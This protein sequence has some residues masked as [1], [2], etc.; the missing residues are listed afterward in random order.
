LSLPLL[1]VTSSTPSPAAS[2]SASSVLPSVT[3]SPT[4]SSGGLPDV[5]LAS[6]KGALLDACG[7]TP[8]FLCRTVYDTTHSTYI[9]SGAEVLLGTPLTILLILVIAA[10]LRTLVHRVI[11]R[12]TSR[13]ASHGSLL[14]GNLLGAF[15]DTAILLERRRQRAETVGSLLRSIVSIV[16]LGIAF[17]LILGE[18]GINLAPIVAS[19]GVLGIAVGF[20]AQNLVKDFL[21]GV[22]MLLEDQYGVGDVVDVGAVSGTV[23]AVTFRMTRLR[24][25]E[26]TVWYVRNGEITRIG[27]KSQQWARTVL[28]VPLDYD[29]DVSTAKT[30]LLETARDMWR[31]D[32]WAAVILAEPEVWGI[33]AMTADGYDLRV[34]IKTQ[35][36][37]QWDVA[38]ELR[39]RVR[40]A[41]GAAGITLGA[42][43]RS[44]VVVDDD[45]DAASDSDD[46]DTAG[47]GQFGTDTPPRIDPPA[48]PGPPSTGPR[49]GDAPGAPSRAA[50]GGPSGSSS[51]TGSSGAAGSGAGSGDSGA[52]AGPTG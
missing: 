47:P 46:D 3:P 10:V 9:A 13:L 43:Q 15:G 25:V 5:T 16:V 17:I 48:Q 30:L 23:E 52:A 29:T 42:M 21:S 11:R 50:T 41:L 36:L 27:N 18:L 14:R 45:D 35:P 7:Q 19:A 34:A 32:H 37:K 28:D 4:P 6:V 44:V 22:F 40:L 20:G 12:T 1:A 38:R 26:G 31:D 51:T 8:G 24:D 49:A 33:E 2:P 39:E